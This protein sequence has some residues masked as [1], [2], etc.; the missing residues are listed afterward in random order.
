[1]CCCEIRLMYLLFWGIS[2][3]SQWGGGHSVETAWYKSEGLPSIN[4]VPAH[5]CFVCLSLLVPLGRSPCSTG[6]CESQ[7]HH[8]SQWQQHLRESVYKW[9]YCPSSLPLCPSLSL[10]LFIS[11]S[12]FLSLSLHVFFCRYLS[13]SLCQYLLLGPHQ[14]PVDKPDPVAPLRFWF[15]LP[16]FLSLTWSSLSLSLSLSGP[17]LSPVRAWPPVICRPAWLITGFLLHHAPPLAE[18]MAR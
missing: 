8:H 14:H 15:N 12:L 4:G 7:A 1:M 11:L 18:V 3:W 10:A 13:F 16:P 5:C 2:N 9:A 6:E 17:L